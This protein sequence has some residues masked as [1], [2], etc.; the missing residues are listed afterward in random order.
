[1]K[2]LIVYDSVFGNTK[3]LAEAMGE[4]LGA[5]VLN[6]SECTQADLSGTGLLIAGSPTRAFRPTKPMTTFLSTLPAGSLAGV[7]A[8]AFDTR[9]DLDE[10]KSRFLEFMVR[11]FGYAAP[12]MEKKLRS[13]G[14]TMA[15]TRGG[16]LI[17]GTEG[18]MKPGEAQRAV[19]WARSCA[20]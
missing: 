12:Q 15:T 20:E 10:V 4:S 19:A 11:L 5:R 16:F 2:T 7:K 9:A 18:P 6:V 13:K 3:G 8:A 1:M 17:H 14:A